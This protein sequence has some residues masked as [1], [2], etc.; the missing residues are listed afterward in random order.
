MK[1]VI[2]L[3]LALTALAIGAIVVLAAEQDPRS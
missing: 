1:S 3:S 2:I